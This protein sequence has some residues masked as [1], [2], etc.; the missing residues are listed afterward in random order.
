MGSAKFND[1]MEVIYQDFDRL[2]K[3]MRQELY[4]RVVFE[5]IQRAED[6]FFDDG[7]LVSYA[8][9][10]SVSVNPGIGFQTDN[11]QTGANSKK[12]LLHRA[13]AATVNLTPADS[14][15]DRIDIILAKQAV[16]TT[17][18]DTRKFK[19]AGSGVISNVAF[20]IEE[21][22]VTE[23]SVVD[24]TPA[25]TPAA[26]ATPAGFIKI[27]ECYMNAV[28][29]M[30]GA[31]DVTDTRDLMPLGGSV[32][33]NTLGKVRVTAGAA[34][35]LSTL[36]TDIDAL[37]HRGYQNYT[38]MDDI[39]SDPA[40]PAA[41]RKRLY[42]KG[43]AMFF[44]NN[45]GTVTPVGSGGGGGGGA[46]WQPVAG[47]APLDDY[48]YNEKTWQF[49]QSLGQELTL[50]I[51]V[52]SSY[53]A[54]RQVKMYSELFSPSSS[55]EWKM[56]ATTALVRKNN[57]AIDSVANVNVANTGDLTNTVANRIR[58]TTINLSS[59]TG[60]INSVAISA[61]D[62]LKVTLTR[63]APAGT[64]DTADISFIPSSTEVTF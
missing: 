16:A 48:T 54:G 12:R 51:R 41:G 22:W 34:V 17:D 57:D 6:S 52:P 45:G 55:N 38:D 50:W 42:F 33:L 30:G 26:P 20:D 64:E 1:G 9:P 3:L 13:S 63:I 28:T 7:F 62:L 15:N 29:G 49:Q 56:Q 8:S 21:D 59:A 61:G 18:T 39:V 5:L 58:E 31:G 37:L 23:L 2:Q 43:D 14:V 10:T 4:E 24:G 27:A 19:D 53:I 32:L 35:P 11:T 44:R 47:N 25:I 46:N 40:V 36:I 60:T